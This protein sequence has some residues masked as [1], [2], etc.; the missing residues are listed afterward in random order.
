[1]KIRLN[2]EYTEAWMV[3]TIKDAMKDFK[4]MYTDGDLKRAFEDATDIDTGYSADIIRCNVDAF[5]A[6]YAF[7]NKPVFAVDM[8]ME[9]HDGFTK[10][11]F[12]VDA[13]LNVDTRT[14]NDGMKSYSAKEYKEI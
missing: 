9:K 8:L 4:A 14:L 3:E 7:D 11:H 1:M 10:I 13:D 5:D 12:Y 6:G 2:K